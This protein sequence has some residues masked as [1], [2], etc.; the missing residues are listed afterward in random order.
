MSTPST[1]H[2]HVVAHNTH[3]RER[4]TQKQF[5]PENSEHMLRARS[6]T[7]SKFIISKNIKCNASVGDVK[8]VPVTH[9]R[10]HQQVSSE[11]QRFWP[12][13][14]FHFMRPKSVWRAATYVRAQLVSTTHT[15]T[16]TQ[17][18][19]LVARHCRSQYIEL[20]C[21]IFVQ[22]K[23]TS[24]SMCASGRAIEPSKW[25]AILK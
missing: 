13:V 2:M 21:G 4:D 5:H 10:L 22:T 19:Y 18:H 9:L 17:T 15:H 11:P 1:E 14:R 8:C 23:T 3:G 7:A 12:S 20:L 6:I 24:Y 25:C 16:H